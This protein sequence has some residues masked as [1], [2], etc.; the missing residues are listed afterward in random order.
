MIPLGIMANGYRKPVLP[1]GPQVKLLQIRGETGAVG[2]NVTIPNFSTTKPG[3][4][5]LALSTIRDPL[6]TQIGVSDSSANV[7]E[8]QAVHKV[9]GNS[10]ITAI[11][12]DPVSTPVQNGVISLRARYADES[13]PVGGQRLWLLEIEGGV[14]AQPPVEHF[15][16]QANI[17][18]PKVLANPGDLVIGFLSTAVSSRT[19]TLQ[20]NEYV[21]PD[22]YK[23]NNV[24]SQVVTYSPT[25]SALTGPAWLR[26]GS[27]SN[28][29]AYLLRFRPV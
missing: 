13:F 2:S 4:S 8:Q 19:Y 23:G 12:L 22:P 27:A 1:S 15:T 10:A 7:Y 24:T 3:T 5:L 25:Q 11:L 21:G 26:S 9:E 18:P 28:S 6:V 14:L 17:T 20:T 29:L 16:T